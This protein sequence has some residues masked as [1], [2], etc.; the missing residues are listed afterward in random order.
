MRAI[1]LVILTNIHRGAKVAMT[2][3]L[4]STKSVSAVVLVDNAPV[5]ALLNSDFARYIQGMRI[6][7]DAQIT[8][9]MEA[10]N[11][12]KAVEKVDRF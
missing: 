2:V 6:V 5:D 7:E 9:Q 4:R 12:L 3:A 1:H 8:K 10:D 11:L